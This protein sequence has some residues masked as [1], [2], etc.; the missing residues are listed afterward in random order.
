[1]KAFYDLVY[2]NVT[3]H[4]LSYPR[5]MSS[6][7]RTILLAAGVAAILLA[8]LALI[9]LTVFDADRYRPKLI[10]YLQER[11]G[12][13]VEIS[14]ISLTLF[15]LTL[16]IENFGMKNA[17]P[18]PA[19]YVAKGASVEIRI[20]T[21][22]LLLHRRFVIHSLTLDQP[23]VNLISDPKGPWNFDNPHFDSRAPLDLGQI[24]RVEIQHGQ[25][26]ASNH[27]PSN[28]PGPVFLEARDLNGTLENVDVGAI[29]SPSARAMGGQGMV[30]ADRMSFGA[31]DGGNLSFKLQL[32]AQ[33][34]FLA[35]VK[36]DISG[37]HATGALFFDLTGKRPAFS[38]NA[39]FVGIDVADLLDPFENGRGKMTGRMDGD[40]TLAGEIQHS[41]RP[42]A[43]IRGNGHVILNR[44]EVPSLELNANLAKLVRFNNH[45]PATAKSS[46]FER[47]STDFQL[48]NLRIRSEKIDIDGYGVDVDGAGSF[49]ADGSNELNYDG[50]A[51][52]T[53]RQGFFTNTFA[54]IAGANV[55]K[56][57]LSFPFHVGGTIET[58]VFFKR[59]IR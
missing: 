17:P 53:T 41:V 20:D 6:R 34:V 37:G 4:S 32:W 1:M 39:R 22:Q 14:H 35:E 18:F 30:R 48:A 56:G 29:V 52:I 19:G 23:S 40:L 28:A 47:I 46:S 3:A 24:G 12:K 58:P 9:A 57:R 11:T 45:G 13:P 38:C 26:V 55:E 54:R 33:Q 44:G 5:T 59:A 42:L 7:S 2:W 21:R 49:N 43:G 10:S 15:P 36:A 51:R 50:L 27:L 31:V 25:L 8:T 16:R